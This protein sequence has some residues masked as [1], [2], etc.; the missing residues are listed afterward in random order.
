MTDLIEATRTDVE[1]DLLTAIGTHFAHPAYNRLH[2]E[3][4]GQM[5]LQIRQI[6]GHTPLHL[7]MAER[8]AYSYIKSIEVARDPEIPR[9]IEVM[10]LNS[11][12]RVA[13]EM[14]RETRELKRERNFTGSL[15]T[16]ILAV[17]QDELVA[18][19]DV[20]ARIANRLETL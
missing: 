9:H 5:V 8:A 2:Q 20:A 19:P 4:Y 11:F 7:M 1:V 13:M 18:Y 14:G 16:S 3:L 17:L 15:I 10:Y 6:P 12:N